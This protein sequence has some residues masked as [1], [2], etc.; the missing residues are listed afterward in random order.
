MICFGIFGPEKDA[1]DLTTLLFILPFVVIASGSGIYNGLRRQ[2][3]L[4]ESFEIIITENVITRNQLNTP[5]VE[6]YFN[7]IKSIAKNGDNAIV[8]TGKT[9]TERIYIPAQIDHYDELEETLSAIKPFTSKN[10]FDIPQRFIVPVMAVTMGA[11]VYVY[12]GTNKILVGISGMVLSAI[13]IYG[14]YVLQTNKSVDKKNK[15]S[16][17]WVIVVAVSVIFVMY[18]KLVE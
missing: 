1:M 7:E 12:L 17:W 18:K 2:K 6:I 4:C 11:M 14:F 5:V 16:S 10:I 13:M 9:P 15:R 8:I 3:A